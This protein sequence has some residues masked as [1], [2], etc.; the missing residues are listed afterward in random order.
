MADH[1]ETKHAQH[2]TAATR[3]D[4]LDAV[5]G[6]QAN[7]APETIVDAD[8]VVYRKTPDGLV[9]ED[10]S[11]NQAR[12]YRVQDGTV[13]IGNLAFAG[14]TTL[15][16]IAIPQGVRW[17]GDSAF[18]ACENLATAVLPDSLERIEDWAFF[19]S[20]IE[21]LHIPAACSHIG[22]CALVADGGGKSEM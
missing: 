13:G 11:E 15:E 6:I 14:N 17:I 10:A 5:D 19:G 16:M 1:P 2:D 22:S 9:L 18:S 20:S 7:D 12:A 4:A 3:Q 8:G 21:S